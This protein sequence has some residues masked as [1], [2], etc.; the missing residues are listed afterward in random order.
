MIRCTSWRKNWL[1][2][3]TRASRSP[4][5]RSGNWKP[6]WKP[7]PSTGLNPYA[8]R[9]AR[10]LSGETQNGD[11]TVPLGTVYTKSKTAP[12]GP[13]NA[14]YGHSANAD[15]QTNVPYTVNVEAAKPLDA[16]ARMGNSAVT[17]QGV[18]SVQDGDVTVTLS[19]GTKVPL[20]DVEIADP[21]I[22]QLYDTAAKY[23]TN[24]AKAFVS[25][26]DGSLPI[27][28]YQ[29]AFDYFMTQA[30]HGVSMDE[31]MQHAG[32]AGQMMSPVSRQTAYFAGENLQSSG[33]RGNMGAENVATGGM[34]NVSVRQDQKPSVKTRGGT[35][36]VSGRPDG[37]GREDIGKRSG[38]SEAGGRNVEGVTRRTV[39]T[40]RGRPIEFNA[41][42]DSALSEKQKRL[43]EESKSYGYDLFFSPRGS[44]FT[45]GGKSRVIDWVAFVPPGERLVFA[46]YET[47]L[48]FLHH[49]LF[50]HFLKANRHKESALFKKAQRSIVSKSA[51]KKYVALC[52]KHYKRAV[53]K[54][55]VLEEITCDLCEYAMSGSKPL[56]NRLNGL[57]EGDTLET[58]A[59]Q[60]R[61]V[62]EANR[63]A[64]QAGKGQKSADTRFYMDDAVE[65]VRGIR[66]YH[67]MTTEDLDSAVQSGLP[68]LH[69]DGA[70]GHQPPFPPGSIP[71]I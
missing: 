71:F 3:R 42:E 28:T 12:N 31:A 43:V 27:S 2:G 69:T 63:E 51:F 66:A 52:E 10:T 45:Y 23:D 26:F 38:I 65:E 60:A 37:R 33:S 30:K 7:K 9:W 14:Q 32:L 70:R 47:K 35:E 39:E 40:R 59:E 15:V 41:V 64:Y 57:F 20:Y 48:D 17:V 18:E 61:E 54:K 67:G 25:G 11:E 58:L 68:P 8:A 46:S 44:E 36:D 50:H 24:T 62:F 4:Q 29:S 21:Q 56:Y 5:K 16:Q 49:E 6:D 19:D 53:S 1:K 55:L 13:S 34:N 22:R